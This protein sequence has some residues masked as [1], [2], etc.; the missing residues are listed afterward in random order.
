MGKKYW[1]KG[2]HSE[3]EYRIQSLLLNLNLIFPV[4]RKKLCLPFPIDNCYFSKM[5]TVD[6]FDISRTKLPGKRKTET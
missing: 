4:E 3:T 6:V 5:N 2:L 1:N